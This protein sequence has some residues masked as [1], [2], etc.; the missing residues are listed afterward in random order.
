MPAG[1]GGPPARTAVT[2][3]RSHVE[4]IDGMVTALERYGPAPSAG[5]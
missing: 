5:V 1:T 2:A 3:E 4:E